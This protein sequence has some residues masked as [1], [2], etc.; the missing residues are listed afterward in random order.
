MLSLS[1]SVFPPITTISALLTISHIF[2]IIAVIRWP[3]YC[4]SHLI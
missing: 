4:Q 2:I 3:N 1:L